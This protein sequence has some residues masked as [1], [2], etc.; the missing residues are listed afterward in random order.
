MEAVSY[1]TVVI[2]VAVHTCHASRIFSAC[3]PQIFIINKTICCCIRVVHTSSLSHQY[4]Y[5]RPLMYYRLAFQ[6]R[7]KSYPKRQI[8][9]ACGMLCDG[10]WW[11]KKWACMLMQRHA[12]HRVEQT[13]LPC[14]RP[15]ESPPVH[16]ILCLSPAN[17][18]CFTLLLRKC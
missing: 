18:K 16:S 1:S 10:V 14:T 17:H 9:G 2:C 8:P 4:M 3:A 11:E 7:G 15:R 13:P 12:S 5:P 6:T